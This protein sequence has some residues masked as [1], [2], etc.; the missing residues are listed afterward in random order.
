MVAFA[1]LPLADNKVISVTD[2]ELICSSNVL[3]SCWL[4]L[5]R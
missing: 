2:W 3:K 1:F 4:C 5:Q